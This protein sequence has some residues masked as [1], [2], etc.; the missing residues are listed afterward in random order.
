MDEAPI[1]NEASDS[2][3]VKQDI[4]KAEHAVTPTQESESISGRSSTI[5]NRSSYGEKT[6]T[7]A[8]TGTEEQTSFKATPDVSVTV[9]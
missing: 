7:R 3:E 4:E 6:M 9:A 5:G 8:S 2:H 1:A